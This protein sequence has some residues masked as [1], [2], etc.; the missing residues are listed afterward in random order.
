MVSGNIHFG[1]PSE[2]ASTV[3]PRMI[4]R[5]SQSYPGIRLEVTSDL[6]RNLQSPAIKKTFDLILALNDNPKDHKKDQVKIDEL[7]WVSSPHSNAQTQTPI[8]LVVA[9]KGC[10]YRNKAI[11]VLE[12]R[13]LASR[14]V[15]TIP[16]LMGIKAAV[17]AGLGVTVLAKSTV[18]EGLSILKNSERFPKLGSIG[19]HLMY[20]KN[21]TNTAVLR[22]IEFV[23]ASLI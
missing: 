4:G 14:I 11:K 12:S 18:P 7:V 8:P 20:K 9:P 10:I 1:M 16:D 23:K 3:L 6:S 13:Q 22:L 15:Y 2:F 19:I 21:Q 5:F 17:E